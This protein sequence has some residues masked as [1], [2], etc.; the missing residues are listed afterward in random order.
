[1]SQLGP[2]MG[3]MGGGGA[4]AGGAQAAGGEAAPAEEENAEPAELKAPVDEI[5]YSGENM[6]RYSFGSCHGVFQLFR[7]SFA[8]KITVS[9]VVDGYA[10]FR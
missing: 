5:H 4:P 8:H 2:F 9:M 3:M 6:Q 10:L 1:M 7:R